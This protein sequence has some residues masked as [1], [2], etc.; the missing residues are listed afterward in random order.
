MT[1]TGKER[2][3][4]NA[5]GNLMKP[6]TTRR[7]LIASALWFVGWLSTYLFLGAY[8]VNRGYI[9]FVWPVYELIVSVFHANPLGSA[10]RAAIAVFIGLIWVPLP[11]GIIKRK[12]ELIALPPGILFGNW[13]SGIMW[14]HAQAGG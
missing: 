5:K 4:K 7:T 6:E 8:L 10:L 2:E 11:L 12:P 14:G 13:F 9:A 3:K 1:S